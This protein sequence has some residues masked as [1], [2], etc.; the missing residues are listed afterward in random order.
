MKEASGSGEYWTYDIDDEDSYKWTN[1]DENL[2]ILPDISNSVS[3]PAHYPNSNLLSIN[4]QPYPKPGKTD[5]IFL[6]VWNFQQESYVLQLNKEN[7]PSNI[8]VYLYDK[9]TNSKKL[10]TGLYNKQ[11]TVT[12]TKK[13]D[14]FRFKLLIHN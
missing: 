11:F 12:T 10:I 9:Y 3:S 7:M 8:E 4:K 14:P 1:P 2:G 5:T 13:K 6:K